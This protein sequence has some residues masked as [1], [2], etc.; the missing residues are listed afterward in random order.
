MIIF[1]LTCK[2]EH[3]FE[4]WFNSLAT[5]ES[6]LEN[7]LISCPHCGSVEIRRV[8]SAPH[9]TKPPVPSSAAEKALPAAPPGMFAAYQQLMA[10]IVSNCEDVG[11]K[12]ADEARKIHYMEAPLRA[13]RGQASNEDYESL[14]DEGIEVLR[15]PV[16]KK[17][18]LN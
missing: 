1:D 5:Y 2:Q 16:V 12:F 14:R 3:R 6:Q 11:T 15:V 17:E 8:P 9:L 10:T 13:I 18:D 4:G 7:G